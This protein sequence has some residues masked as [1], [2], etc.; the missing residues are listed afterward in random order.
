MRARKCEAFSSLH[1]AFAVILNPAESRM[2]ETTEM[3]RSEIEDGS[4]IADMRK[5][6]AFS[7]FCILHSQ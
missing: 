1:L 3:K 7:S 6:E 4:I 5:C 2:V